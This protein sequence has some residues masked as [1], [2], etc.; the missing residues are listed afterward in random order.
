MIE[1][2][3]RDKGPIPFSAAAGE[4]GAMG[5]GVSLLQNLDADPLA[6]ELEARLRRTIA[7][8]SDSS[9]WRPESCK[10]K[11]VRVLSTEDASGS[12]PVYTA[13]M[14]LPRSKTQPVGPAL[15]SP[16]TL[17]NVARIVLAATT[18]EDIQERREWDPLALDYRVIEERPAGYSVVYSVCDKILGGLIS[19]RD[20]AYARLVGPRFHFI[21]SLDGH[22]D[23]L[24]PKTVVETGCVR[25]LVSEI[26]IQI[27]PSAEPDTVAVLRYVLHVDPRGDI[28]RWAVR[29]TLYDIVVEFVLRM[30]SFVERQIAASSASATGP[31]GPSS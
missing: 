25:A 10:K 4:S 21:T 30:A 24:I 26:F 18:T 7:L 2:V 9:R 31:P 29:R 28:P 19:K 5:S 14:S 27:L 16:W 8:L 1:G 15:S 23:D 6:F 11:G 22:V 20:Y 17:E 3:S 12:Y 13:E